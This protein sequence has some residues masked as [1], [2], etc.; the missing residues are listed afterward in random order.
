[1]ARKACVV[2][3]H[4][5]GHF[6]DCGHENQQTGPAGFNLVTAAIILFNCRYL[7]RARGKIRSRGMPIDVTLIP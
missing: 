3:F 4:S 7:G 1:M 5:L 6:R 2:A